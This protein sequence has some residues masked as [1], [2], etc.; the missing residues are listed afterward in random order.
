MSK[1]IK[2][3]K[4]F[5]INLKGKADKNIGDFAK[6]EMYAVKPSDFI[7]VSRP[8]LEVAEGDKVKA[9]DPIFFDKVQETVKFLSPVSGEVTEIIR[10][11]KRRLLEIR[12]KADGADSYAE[13]KKYST[14]DIAGISKDEALNNMCAGGVWPH[15]IQRPYAV[16]ANP[17]DT[18]KAIHIS[19]FDSAP[20][21]CD[22]GFALKDDKE[23]FQAGLD[24]LKKFTNG[25]VHLNVHT[26]A[27]VSP[28]FEHTNGTQLNKF[29]GPH[30]AGNVGVQIHHLDPINKGDVVWTVAPYGVAQIGK[31]FLEGKYDASKIVSVAGSSI[32]KPRYA[33]IISGANVSTLLADNVSE[34][35]VRVI[36]G[37]VL[38]G[39]TIAND[40]YIGFYDNEI[41]VI[42]EGNEAEFFG[43]IL[44]TAKKLSF[45]RAIGLMSFMGGKKKEY[46]INTN[47]KGEERAFVQSGAFEKVVPMDIYP[48]YLIKAILAQDYEEMEALGIYEIAE[49]DF[50]LCEF[51]DVSK[52]DIQNIVREGIEML[53]LS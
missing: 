2:I 19:S 32:V 49:E 51:I 33:K 8:K 11:E 22:L 44:P 52:N 24:I 12:I 21:S 47:L 15:I 16:V 50:A 35:N 4:G 38:T 7:H 28:V 18:P 40:G 37:D 5:D 10:G 14:S 23:N 25:V 43:W 29:S 27:E 6:S 46:E 41:C 1:Q 3:K 36:S 53:R 26:D 31:L 17:A 30:P 34:D 45:H 42:P 9:G 20:L 13:F 39:Q 48:T